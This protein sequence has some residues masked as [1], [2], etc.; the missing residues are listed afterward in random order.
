[1]AKAK[2]PEPIVGS[3]RLREIACGTWE[4]SCAQQRYLLEMADE[5]DRLTAEN[6]TKDKEIEKLKA[7]QFPLEPVCERCGKPRRCL[8]VMFDPHAYGCKP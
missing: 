8:G 7:N 2:K 6:V 4:K 3:A 1:M 5:F